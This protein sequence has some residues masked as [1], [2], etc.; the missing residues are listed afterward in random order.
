MRTWV[1]SPGLIRSRVWRHE[2]VICVLGSRRKVD[3]WSLRPVSLGNIG[4]LQVPVQDPVSKNRRQ[5]LRY[6]TSGLQMHM[7]WNPPIYRPVSEFTHTPRDRQHLRTLDCSYCPRE[8]LTGKVVAP[9]SSL[10]QTA[11]G[12]SP[13]LCL[14]CKLQIKT[15]GQPFVSVSLTPMFSKPI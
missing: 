15:R 12:P 7:L 4:E 3:A 13:W 5:V 11:I 10:S 6:D 8:I 9:I 1:G 2:P 14:F